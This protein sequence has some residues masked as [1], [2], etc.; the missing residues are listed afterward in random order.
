VAD[1]APQGERTEA[2]TPRRQQRA[3]EEGQVPISREMVTLAG[4]AAV[5]LALIWAAPG[6]TRDL[7]QGLSTFMARAH[8]FDVTDGSAF[9]LAGVLWLRGSA[10][11]VLAAMLAG[12]AAVLV[13]S[14][15]LLNTRA[16]RVDLSRIS[17]RAGFKRLLSTDSLIEAVKSV[18]K[19]TVLAFVAWHVLRGDL[20][21]LV[22]ALFSEPNQ[23]LARA[24]GPALHV[25][26]VVLAAQTG[27]AALDTFWVFLR[28]SQQ[29]R[30]S[31][32]D[33]QEEQKE[34]EGDPR[35]KA[36]IQQIRMFR[37]RKR[38]LAAVPKATVVITNP[39]HYAVALSYDRAKHAA[40]RVVAKGVDSLAARIREVA[41]ANRVPMVANPP[42][43][44]ALYR[45][46]LDADIPAEHYQA[47]AEIIAYVWRLGRAPVKTMTPLNTGTP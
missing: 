34:T 14:R 30:M 11:F 18:V 44:H 19:V 6:A 24:A 35:V 10:P 38:M 37:A 23:L 43:A 17:P 4:M 8:E 21:D 41:T 12:V 27:I 47:V 31:R 42:L 20:P 5:T 29:L 13:Q 15:F 25:M 28:Q 1:Q 36:R 16:L 7:A 33:I 26:Y 45:V 9:R 40:P 22:L 39:T 2:A 32:H 3:R 46:E